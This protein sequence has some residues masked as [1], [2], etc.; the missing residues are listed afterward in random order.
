MTS[1]LESPPFTSRLG[2]PALEG[3]ILSFA[4]N[5][6]FVERDE[7]SVESIIRRASKATYPRFIETSLQGMIPIKGIPR[8]ESR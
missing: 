1:Y 6:L 8:G 3:R 7:R 2:L 4:E 5:T